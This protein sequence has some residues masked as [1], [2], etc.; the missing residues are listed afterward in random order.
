MRLEGLSVVQVVHAGDGPDDALDRLVA[1]LATGVA[2]LLQSSSQHDGSA[3][4]NLDFPGD[5]SVHDSADHEA[6]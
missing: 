2:R 5:P 1:L 4:A 6:E 3:A